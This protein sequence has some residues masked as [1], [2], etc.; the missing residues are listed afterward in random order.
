MKRKK[1]LFSILFLAMSAFLP[2]LALAAYTY[3]PMEQIPGFGAPTDFPS[4]LT[5]LYKFGLW[6]IGLAALLMISIGG[7]MY[8][9]SAGNNSQ[10]GK[11]KSYITDAIIGVILALVAYLLLYTINPDLVKFTPL[12][13]LPMPTSLGTSSANS[14]AAAQQAIA[15][16][17]QQCQAYC[18]NAGATGSD[19]TT[20]TQNCLNGCTQNAQNAQQA[21]AN[22][23]SAAQIAKNQ[24]D[25]TNYCA[26]GGSDTSISQNDCYSQCMAAK[27][28]QAG[29]STGSAGAGNGTCTS[30]TDSSNPCDVNNLSSTCFGSNAQQAASICN[31]ESRGIATAAGDKTTDGQPVSIGLF[32]INLTVHPVAGL[33]CPQAFSG[34]Y[35]GHNHSIT[36]K[37]QNLYNSCVAAAKDPT[38][39]IN[40]AC[41]ISNGGAHWGQ[42]STNQGCGFNK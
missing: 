8:I 18:N 1:I 32:Q 12:T 4:Y 38:N 40:A 39:N 28:A 16:Q 29:T 27:S 3:T 10:M 6:T 36:I 33:P 41:G 7:F 17:L 23:Q 5:A 19:G 34:G 31:A 42:W 30:P 14:Q 9:T 2:R 37:D 26:N 25:C 15:Q 24:Q 35:S 13:A 21:A 22:G 20:W 11:A